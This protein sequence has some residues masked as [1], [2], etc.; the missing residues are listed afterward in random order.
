MSPTAKALLDLDDASD[1]DGVAAAMPCDICIVILTASLGESLSM[2]SSGGQH[3]A[4]HE[5]LFVRSCALFY[6]RVCQQAFPILEQRG[7][8][9]MAR[10][11]SPK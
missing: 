2:L 3:Q 6:P 8:T 7:T 4:E 11:V 9:E 10:S 1:S 5:A